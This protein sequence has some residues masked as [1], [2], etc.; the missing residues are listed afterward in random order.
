MKIVMCYIGS[1]QESDFSEIMTRWLDRQDKIYM[2][3]GDEIECMGNRFQVIEFKSE[4][5][6]ILFKAVL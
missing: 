6:K 5:N 1:W 4:E 3:E 2:L